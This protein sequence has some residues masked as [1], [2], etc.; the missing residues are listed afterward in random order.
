M[1][2]ATRRLALSLMIAAYATALSLPAA[3]AGTTLK[4]L[5]WGD[6][7]GS[8]P[9]DMGMAMNKAKG[10]TH[11]A[12]SHMGITIYENTIKAGEVTFEVKNNSEKTIHEMLVLPIKN[13]RTPPPYLKNENRLD[14]TKTNSLGE[15]SELDPGKSGTLTLNLKPGKYLL[16]CNVPGHYAAGMWTVLTV[17]PYRPV[18]GM[19]GNF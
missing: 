9:T 4:A 16:A 14:E 8:M 3:A 7:T 11:G 10:A 18:R 2:P 12:N 15:V 6:I 13:T 1:P 19:V 5:L 17:K